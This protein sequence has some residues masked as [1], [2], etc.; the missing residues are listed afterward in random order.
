MNLSQRDKAVIWHPFTQAQTAKDPIAIVKAEGIWLYA[1]DGQRYLDGT[2]SWW[3]NAHGHCH[4]YIAEQIAQQ[5]AQLEH[6]IFAGFTHEPAVLLAEK[7]I[8]VLPGN[9]SR[10]FYSDK[11]LDGHEDHL[12]AKLRNLLNLSH[13]VM[14]EAKM[15]VLAE[16]RGGS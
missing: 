3:V 7:L 16:I 9:Q 5:A 6:I 4:P 1:E 15:R 14:I 13:P 2:S 11:H 12:A 8:A 10:I